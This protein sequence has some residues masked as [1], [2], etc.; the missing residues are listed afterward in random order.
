MDSIDRDDLLAA[1]LVSASVLLL[2]GVASTMNDIVG[3][4][5]GFDIDVD[6]RSG[7]FEDVNK[8]LGNESVSGQGVG[9]EQTIDLVICIDALTTTPAILG[10]VAGVGLL[11]Y[12][13]ARRYNAATSL[14]AG[15]AVVPIVWGAYFLSTNCPTADSGGWTL[16]SGRSMVTNTGG[17][18]SPSLPPEVVAGVLGVI[19][20]A[21]LGLLT[22]I[23]RGPDEPH[24]V[25]PDEPDTA[26]AA[27]AR[28]AGRAADRIDAANKPVD[29]AVYRAWL[30]MTE[31]LDLEHP[32]T[33]APRDFASAATERGFDETAVAELTELFTDVRY[34]GK[35]A[36]NREA[37]AI[38][39]LRRIEE[40]Y[41]DADEAAED[42]V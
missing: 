41:Q 35:R 23:S 39:I 38:E 5:G 30:E 42:E 8:S 3:R 25:E 14:L 15:T 21:G 9:G 12:G 26:G 7:G 29:N 20:I 28:A 4:D 6:P 32:E 10:I 13:L 17:I 18:R 22:T 34:G 16:L 27:V 31:S 24:E 33:T 40:T 2:G 1:V 36:E 37:R 11:L 19:V